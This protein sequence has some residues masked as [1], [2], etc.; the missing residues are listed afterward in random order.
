MSAARNL[1]ATAESCFAWAY[2]FAPDGRATAFDADDSFTLE[3]PGEGFVW[4]HLSLA[5]SRSRQWIDQSP[6]IPEPARH[7]L[8]TADE[9]SQ[10]D[11]GENCIWGVMADLVRDI[12]GATKSVGFMHFVLAEHFLVSARRHPLQAAH[13]A[14]ARIDAGKLT[15]A[16][17]HLFENIVEHA[18]AAIAGIVSG[19][20][21]EIEAIE[22]RVLDEE[23][24]DERMTLGPIRRNCL[25]LH[26]QLEGMANVFRRLD[27]QIDPALPPEIR[28]SAARLR[29]KIEGLHQEVHSMQD[30]TRLLQE[31]TAQ[32]LANKTND[33]LFFLTVI[34][35][36]LLPP[37]LITGM[38]GMNVKGMLFADSDNGYLY[39]L[40]LCAAASLA[41]FWWM[42]RT[43]MFR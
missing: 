10:L 18:L 30:R 38:F 35:A 9:H 15:P 2:R 34:S 17:A 5:D 23:V 28:T 20:V 11:S 8:V 3:A 29:Q 24:H 7:A 37:T 14:R 31:E 12:D 16:P 4:L 25:R 33:N 1:A 32:K 22:D 21:K 39:A 27:Q 40:A 36:L 26:R 13:C 43:G 41:V 19:Y 42:R 6:Q